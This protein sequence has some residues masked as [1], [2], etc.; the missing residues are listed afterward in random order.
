MSRHYLK[1]HTTYNEP[2][3]DDVGYSVEMRIPW[4]TLPTVGTL[5][6]V[7]LLSVDHDNN[8]DTEFDDPDTVFSKVFWD[9]D[10]T[11]DKSE[12]YLLLEDN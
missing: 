12:G 6:K 3:N 10:S 4:I 7:D 8:P 5:V 2:K 1:D 9:N 11:V